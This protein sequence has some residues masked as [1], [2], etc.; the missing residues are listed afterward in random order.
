MS[1]P[2]NAEHYFLFGTAIGRCGIAWSERGITRILLPAA[3]AA[4]TEKKLSRSATKADA[5]PDAIAR[6]ISDIQRYLT[7]NN[8]D[9]SAVAVDL[10]D[11]SDFNAKI[12][13]AARKVGFGCTV[14]Y[15]ELARQA[16]FVGA[17]RDVGQTM[18]QNPVPIIVPCHRVVP[19]SGKVGGF[20]APGGTFTKE[21]LL[22]LEG[23]LLALTMPSPLR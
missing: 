15:G 5:P 20:S 13:A 22:I 6:L 3:N 10:K 1:K 17:A 14:T 12:Y 16:G 21:R 2:D 7:G 11:A 4:A 8:V 19:A 9:F 18:G 23:A